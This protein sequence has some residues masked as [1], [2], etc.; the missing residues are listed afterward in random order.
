MSR[1]TF[2]VLFFATLFFPSVALAETGG[3]YPAPKIWGEAKLKDWALPLAA[4]A[5]DEVHLS[6]QTYYRVEATNLRTYP[7]YHPDHEPPGYLESLRKRGPQPLIETG[8]AYSKAEWQELGA[9][10]FRELDHPAFRTDSPDLHRFVQDRDAIAASKLPIYD[11]GIIFSIR[12]IVDAQGKLRLTATECAACH[13]Q[14]HADGSYTAAGPGNLDTTAPPLIPVIDSGV[15]KVFDLPETA[16]PHALAKALF[17]VPWIDDDPHRAF[18][19]MSMQELGPLF[20]NSGGTFARQGGSPYWTTKIPDLRNVR[21]KRF[22]DATGTHQNR[23][24]ADIARYAALVSGA[25][26]GVHGPHQLYG[27]NL[28]YARVA[29][30][31]LYAIGEYLW[32][33]EPVPNKKA[34]EFEPTLVARGKEIFAAKNCAR[35]HSG[36]NFGGEKLTLAR[37]YSAPRDHAVAHAIIRQSVGTDPNLAL[38]TRKGTGLYRVPPLRGVWYR[39]LYGHSGWVNSLDDW[40]NPARLKDDFRPTGWVGPHGSP[41]A[42]PGHRFGTDLSEDDRRALIAYLS[43]L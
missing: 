22:L 26:S 12:W 13:T 5:P 20:F 19:T 15:R 41:R 11:N 14:F 28:P 1:L 31:V 23:E 17:A 36:A 33:L 39:N 21:F 40:F 18:E 43:T 42:I 38:K 3:R 32:S 8:K 7:V 4:G 29:D 37:G 35:C 27:E 2:L 25:S 9:R 34:K 10:A 24:P 16:S 30:E 6:E